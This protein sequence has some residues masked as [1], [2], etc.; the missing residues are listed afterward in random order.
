M[1]ST[2]PM[3]HPIHY[4]NGKLPMNSKLPSMLTVLSQDLREYKK[5]AGKM[6]RVQTQYL[7]FKIGLM[8]AE[9]GNLE[10]ELEILNNPPPPKAAK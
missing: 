5:D 3:I 2:F 4:L 1:T 7:Q 9:L 10:Q 6:L 8:K